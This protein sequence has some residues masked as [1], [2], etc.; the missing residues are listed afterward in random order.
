MS[1][2]NAEN[3]RVNKQK[4]YLPSW[5]LDSPGRQKM[6]WRSKENIYNVGAKCWSKK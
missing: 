3:V 1:I 2:L 4:N 5:N 6:N